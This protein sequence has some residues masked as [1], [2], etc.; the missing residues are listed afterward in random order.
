MLLLLVVLSSGL[1][2]GPGRS[3]AGRGGAR[4]SARLALRAAAGAVRKVKLFKCNVV[5]IV[6][7]SSVCMS[8]NV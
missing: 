7:Y 2:A 3:R 1:P 4:A 5:C 6:M 8:F